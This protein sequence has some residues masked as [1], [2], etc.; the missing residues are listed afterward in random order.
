MRRI[1]SQLRYYR[2]GVFPF[3]LP[4]NTFPI[5]ARQAAQA[6]DDNAEYEDKYFHSEWKNLVRCKSISEQL[7]NANHFYNVVA[8]NAFQRALHYTSKVKP[9]S[10]A[11][12]T[13][14]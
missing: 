3:A 6:E 1:T 12:V 2:L 11:L 4:G 14:C 13:V 8:N 5:G 10:P 7:K 9:S